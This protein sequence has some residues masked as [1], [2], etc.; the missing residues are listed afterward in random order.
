[1]TSAAKIAA[2]QRNGRKS[3]G[4]RSASGKMRSCRNAFRHGLAIP[5]SSDV[6]FANQIGPLSDELAATAKQL[7]Q[8]E[9][10]QI[11]ALA[12][13]ELARAQHVKVQMINRAAQEL[14]K[15]NCR[16]PEHLLALAYAGQ[17]KALVKVDRY[18]RRALSRRNRAL[19]ALE[20]V[21]HLKARAV[22][23]SKL[24]AQ[25]V[26][27]FN[28]LVKTAIASTPHASGGAWS[29]PELK[30]L[31]MRPDRSPCSCRLMRFTSANPEDLSQEFVITKTHGRPGGRQWVAI[32]P[33]TSKRVE[34]L[35]LKE[36]EQGI[37]SRHVLG[38][39][40]RSKHSKRILGSVSAQT[41]AEPSRTVESYDII[42][43]QVSEFKNCR[44]GSSPASDN[45][46]TQTEINLRSHAFAEQRQK[47]SE[48]PDDQL[49]NEIFQDAND[50][51]S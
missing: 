51:A 16:D 39:T 24:F 8:R 27:A 10:A 32:C 38:L 35:F 25:P 46:F 22:C 37:G 48:R 29:C 13:L 11:A 36:S 49:E 3:T 28:A 33:K 50:P 47:S 20:L 26:W 31:R 4:P 9:A 45:E 21:P 17:L 12:E 6:A 5:I 23:W 40:Y 44:D 42:L 7:G 14:Q 43:P 41:I 2:N 18:E 34:D 1:M 15:Q 30:D 19:R